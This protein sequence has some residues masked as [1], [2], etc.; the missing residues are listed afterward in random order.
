MNLLIVS[1][2]AGP[3]LGVNYSWMLCFLASALSS[4][5]LLAM[6]LLLQGERLHKGSTPEW[7]C[8]R[9]SAPAT[10]HRLEF[11]LS[12]GAPRGWRPPV[13]ALSRL[14]KGGGTRAK[15][16]N[17]V[18]RKFSSAFCSQ[19]WVNVNVGN[20]VLHLK[21]QL[22]EAGSGVGI[23]S[24]VYLQSLFQVKH[25]QWCSTLADTQNHLRSTCSQ[26][27]WPRPQFM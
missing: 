22:G 19:V 8:L 18:K 10:A 25:P 6:W 20:A 2:Q 5:R 23:S 9:T 4:Q 1:L 16:A 3:W 21:A 14:R 11:R 24:V 27:L 17:G 26:C 12:P 7:K 13:A 15:Q